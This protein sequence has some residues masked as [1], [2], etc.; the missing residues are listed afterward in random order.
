[1]AVEHVGDLEGFFE[2]YAS[3]E[4]RANIL[5]FAA[6]EDMYKV[7]YN[8]GEGFTMHMPERDIVLKRQDNLYVVDWV[9]VGSA[10]TTVQENERLYS[11]EQVHRAKLA[12]KF[13]C[14]CGY[15]SPAEA[16]HII[17]DGNIPLL[18]LEDVESAYK[19]YGQYPEYVKG[20][21]V[22]RTVRRIPVDVMLPSTEV[23]QKH[24]TDVMEIDGGKFLVTVSDPLKLTL[25]MAVENESKQM[26]D[27]GLQ[28]HL[29]MLQSCG[30]EPTIVYANL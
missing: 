5:S 17:H 8:R 16:I 3:K 11:A 9:E 27:M 26:L 10:Y 6:V 25:Q 7:T 20:K 18:M 15:P 30:F 28:G 29:M 22:K 14:N 21:L 12:C 13:I 19:I 1:M 24:S 4:A 23:K 2:V